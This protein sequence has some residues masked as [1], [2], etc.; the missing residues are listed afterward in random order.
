MTK[1]A[2]SQIAVM[3]LS[4]RV[5]HY[6]NVQ[7]RGRPL[8]IQRMFHLCSVPCKSIRYAGPSL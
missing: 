8:F 2:A 3:T 4:W 1:R 5:E 7:A 6:G